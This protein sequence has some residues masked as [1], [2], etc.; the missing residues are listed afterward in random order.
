MDISDPIMQGCGAMMVNTR[1]RVYGPQLWIV[2]SYLSLSLVL[3]FPPSVQ[4]DELDWTISGTIESTF[5]PEEG[6]KITISATFS[7]TIILPETG[8]QAKFAANSNSGIPVYVTVETTSDSFY[9]RS[10]AQGSTWNCDLVNIDH[11]QNIF[12]FGD[13]WTSGGRRRSTENT[14]CGTGE[15]GTDSIVENVMILNWQ[16]QAPVRPPAPP[17]EPEDNSPVGSI[18]EISGNA[19][20]ISRG[21]KFSLGL[22]DS[23]YEGDLIETGANGALTIIFI[24]ESTWDVAENARFKVTKYLYDD[25]S[26]SGESRYS[27]LRGLFVYVSGLIGKDE[28]DD[29]IEIKTPLGNLGIRGTKLTVEYR[30]VDG[31][32]FSTVEVE[33]GVVEVKQKAT[34]NIVKLE[35][36]EKSTTQFRRPQLEISRQ[37]SFQLILSGEAGSTVRVQRSLNLID[38]TDWQS[39]TLGKAPVALPEP[40]DSDVRF[41]RA[42]TP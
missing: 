8:G 14:I 31:V 23:I 16:A 13:N 22:N 11:N 5:T 29:D 4:S 27:V 12:Q 7:K 41:F 9:I 17:P 25:D 20:V 2:W 36:G 30:E 6:S 28:E 38:W 1:R 35:A 37:N 18:I 39:V 32:G 24:D 34:G 21:Q 19:W 42:V 10:N 33:S 3:L 26:Q 15:P 40:S